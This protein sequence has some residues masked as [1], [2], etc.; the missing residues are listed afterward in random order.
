MLVGLGF[1]LLAVG[2]LIVSRRLSLLEDRITKI[3]ERLG[4]GNPPS[5][6]P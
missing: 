4:I 6:L 2:G 5:P 3:E 1:L